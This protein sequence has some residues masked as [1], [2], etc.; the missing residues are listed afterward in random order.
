M[1]RLI[2][3]LIASLFAVPPA[4]AQVAKV[5]LTLQDSAGRPLPDVTCIFT[6][7]GEQRHAAVY[8]TDA[9]GHMAGTVSVGHYGLR[10][11]YLGQNLQEIS[12]NV[13]G[14]TDL[15][16]VVAASPVQEIER[17]VVRGDA[18]RIERKANL[19]TVKIQG[20]PLEA[21]G[22][23][24]DVL[25]EMPRVEVT[26]DAVSIFGHGTPAIFIDGREVQDAN[27][28]ARV[29]SSQ[30]RNVEIT[31][32]PSGRYGVNVGSAIIITTYRKRSEYLGF[33]LYDKLGRRN[34]WTNTAD[35]SGFLSMPRLDILLGI[36]ELESTNRLH[37]EEVFHYGIS[38]GTVDN[39]LLANRRR[40]NRELSGGAKLFYHLSSSHTLNLYVD[41]QPS[42]RKRTV[43]AGDF[44]HQ[45]RPHS[46]STIGE[47][48][49]FRSETL[50]KNQGY[51]VGGGYD[52]Q[53]ERTTAAITGSYY[54]TGAESE[55]AIL[56]GT[57]GVPD[58]YRTVSR[59]RLLFAKG[60]LS[61]RLGDFELSLGADYARTAREGEYS[62]AQ[63]ASD[64][65]RQDRLGGYVGCTYSLGEQWRLQGQ[66]G[67]EYVDYRY[68]AD[69]VLQ[70][71]QSRR[72]LD[73]LPVVTLGY[74][75]DNLALE[76][77]YREMVDRPSYEQLS[78]NHFMNNRYLR[79]DGNPNLRTSRLREV[80]C[81]LSY[82]WLSWEVSYSRVYARVFEV[83]RL[84]D[85]A[86]AIVLVAPMNLPDHNQY[87]TALAFS[88]KIWHLSI[89]GQVGVQLQD[90]HYN[91]QR[92]T[93]PFVAYSL[94][95]RYAVGWGWNL[96]LGVRSHVRGGS[97]AT[98]VTKG[99]INADGR[100]SKSWLGGQLVTQLIADD[101]FNTAYENILLETN[102][103]QRDSFSRGGIRGVFLSVQYRWG[104]KT[105][106]K[107]NEVSDEVQ[108]L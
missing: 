12:V 40:Q 103:I 84:H 105:T 18:E 81:N 56:Y 107:P 10:F 5:S 77:A 23:L 28:L 100:I 32:N 11:T 86:Q 62:R 13:I 37:D 48:L 7:E 46:G 8:W 83:A 74:E 27:E 39:R 76:L 69:R 57:G 59:A 43:I 101:I 20:T 49:P 90:L 72:S 36:H 106:K 42:R 30:I 78:S 97:Y 61:H 47:E 75:S 38:R 85:D 91:G 19:T 4:V 6:P 55:R 26:E 63:L 14:D 45:L 65:F 80:A 50:D 31:T 25:R 51:T 108:R 87:F 35:A 66:L 88:P 93:H 68:Y 21:V 17:V 54:W 96:T 58:A 34:G 15:G 9:Q 98:G 104:M 82:G 102:G 53:T 29:K 2:A 3:V 64:Q 79:W 1:K 60:D 41:A 95:V 99:Y 44:S 71:G 73:L 16:M 92:Y 22:T 67:A 89:N 24:L 94:R 70:P 52:F 33:D